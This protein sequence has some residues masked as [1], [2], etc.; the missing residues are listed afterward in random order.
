MALQIAH[1]AG[2]CAQAD[3]DHH[4]EFFKANGVSPFYGD[5]SKF[6]KMSTAQR[7]SKLKSLGADPDLASQMQPTS[8]VGLTMK[9]LGQGFESNG[10]A[11]LWARLKTYV[12]ANGVDGTVLQD[13]LQTLG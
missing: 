5:Q 11:D 9:C 1:D 6:S 7:R 2:A 8:C 13:G 4:R 3:L 12:N 10:G